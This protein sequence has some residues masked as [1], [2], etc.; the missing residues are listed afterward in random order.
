M[1]RTRIYR[2]QEGVV[3]NPKEYVLDDT[4]DIA[5]FKNEEEA[6]Q[7]VEDQGLNPM[8]Y[9]YEREDAVEALVFDTL[10]S[11]ELALKHAAG[12]VV[13]DALIKEV[14]N[15]VEDSMFNSGAFDDN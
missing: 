9:N 5:Y 8:N 2:H 12:R 15:T 6:R 14:V 4:G 11:L 1:T 7:Y 3:L 13:D 10:Q